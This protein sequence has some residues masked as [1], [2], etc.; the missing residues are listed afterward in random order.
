[1]PRLNNDVSAV[2]LGALYGERRVLGVYGE[3]AAAEVVEL[4]HGFYSIPTLRLLLE[5]FDKANGLVTG[6]QP[7]QWTPLPGRYGW[8]HA[9]PRVLAHR[10][11]DTSEWVLTVMVAGTLDIITEPV[12][13]PH[14]DWKPVR[15]DGQ[16][17][18]E[19]R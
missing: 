19:P 16:W 12:R 1:M 10:L 13:P 17:H 4:E 8:N 2:F 14:F 9:T 5:A 6:P 18:W 7:I 11:E 3:T 15:R